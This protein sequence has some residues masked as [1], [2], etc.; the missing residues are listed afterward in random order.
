VS[1]R[2]GGAPPV[3]RYPGRDRLAVALPGHPGASRFAPD[4][5]PRVLVIGGGIAG[6][7]AATVLAERGARVVVRERVGY[8]GGRVGGWPT[9]LADGTAVTMSRG[10]HAFFRQYYNLRALLART[11]P[12]LTRLRALADYP[13]W[14][15]GGHRESFAAIPRTL[16]FNALGYLMRSPTFRWADLARVNARSA[17]AMLDVSVPGTYRELDGFDA[18]SYL[19]DIR[20]PPAARA[21]ALEVF[22][23]SFFCHPERLSA[24]EL[25]TMFH[26]YFLGSTEGLL[27]DVPTAPFP[28][29][30]W[31]PL[32]EHLR[33]L[34]AQVHTDSGVAGL[35]PLPGGG[36]TVAAEAGP[37]ERADAV[38][39]AADLAGAQRVVAGSPGLGDPDWRER[40][41]GLRGAE[42]FLVSR[43][44]LDLPVRQDRPP[45]LGT[46]GYDL[47]DNISVLDRY[48]DQAQ[49]WARRTG[50]SVVELHGYAVPPDSDEDHLHQRLV[51]QLHRVYPET[52]AASVVDQRRELRADC[53][54][55]PPGG[56]ANRPE[57]AT[58]DPR[59]VLAGDYVR[60][61]LPVALMERAA[62]TGFLAA[63]A[64]LRGWGVAGEPLWSV[65]TA[66]RNPVLRA[67][68]RRW[69]RPPVQ[70]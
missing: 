32:R 25:V 42:P 39:L 13:L 24:G 12:A 6:L 5:R 40:I 58:P 22:S 17:L 14:H 57:V 61:D 9:T 55:F 47:L 1:R 66:G 67:A 49:R 59:L 50:G 63:N 18:A 36:F 43:L 44:W 38:V 16:P 48:E 41:A 68:A 53:P 2:P 69:G 65:P 70:S 20:F 28:E 4:H 7:A 62:T 60:A 29:A 11:D 37:D 10:F 27:F 31:D 8:L 54:L 23:R 34:G 52:A 3:G 64:L 45:F 35:A 46:S 33:G 51:A 19:R 30:L 15:A 56:F 21:L 26:I